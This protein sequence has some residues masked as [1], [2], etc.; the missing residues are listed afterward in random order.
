MITEVQDFLVMLET[1]GV[2]PVVATVIL[3]PRPPEGDIRGDLQRDEVVQSAIALGA[4]VFRGDRLQGLLDATETRGMQ[5][6]RAGLKTT[7]VVIPHPSA[8]NQYVNLRVR[9][10]DTEINVDVND[11]VPSVRVEVDVQAEVFE[12]TAFV[13]PFMNYEALIEIKRELAVVV[14]D[15]IRAALRAAQG[16]ESDVFGFGQALHCRHPREWQRLRDGWN[17]VLADLSVQVNVKGA[18]RETGLLMRSTR[19]R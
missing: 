14:T 9:K 5:W 3:T 18:I 10:V 12:M 13:D 6:V 7:E 19:I 2:E 15:E 17:E 16:Y 8:A 4:A 11:G 1:E